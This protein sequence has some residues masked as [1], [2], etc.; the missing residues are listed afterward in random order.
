M[1]FPRIVAAQRLQ[2]WLLITALVAVFVAALLVVDLAR[3]LRTVVISD[4]SKAL[5]NAVK[6]LTQS[7]IAWQSV[8]RSATDDD[9]VETEL[10][11]ASYEVLRSYPDV[12]GGFMRGS[13]VF[14]HTFPTY[15]E[16]GSTLRQAPLEAKEVSA[17]LDES[18]A[19]GRIVTRIV[20]DGRD[21]VV[22]TTIA[23]REG[24][25]SA[26][27]LRRLFN[28]SESNEINQRML[29]V[30][31]MI[32]ALGAILVVLR[33]SFSLQR[34]FG[35]IQSGLE[36]LRTDPNYRLPDQAHELKTIVQAVNQMAESRQTVEGELRREDRLR[37]MGRVVAGIAHE[38]RNPLNSIRLTVRVL[39][40]RLQHEATAEEPISLITAEIDR[41]DSL[42]KSLLVFRAEETE[43][44][45]MQ[46]VE[47]ILQR[48]IALVKH[49]A[50]ERGISIALNSIPEST[51]WVDG[52]YL[53][54]ALMNL[55]LNAI[56]ASG[57]KGLVEVTVS[58]QGDRL[59]VD[60]EDSG[61]GLTAEQQDRLFE[62]FYTTKT[63]GTGLGLAVTKTLLE[64]MGASIRS[65]NG[66]KGARF[67]VFLPTEQ[68]A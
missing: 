32:V 59:E 58:L 4:T 50:E 53:Q 43:K 68:V 42:L 47:P 31:A 34:G 7:G 30:G 19:S 41:L 45:R 36:K 60:I 2:T 13:E 11:R 5:T 48:T 38:I 63:G 57:S 65:G 26:W 12:E 28:F 54:Q 20:H 17:G 51:A 22:V 40:R 37:M 16:P 62:A 49:H 61:P 6:E 3:N 23:G 24:E 64:K 21:L 55:L 14:G 10:S 15:T 39:A 46:P 29:L 44:M 52:D 8:R 66:S 18:R 25:L 33:L 67:E 1:R 35:V 27:C 56:D 9:V